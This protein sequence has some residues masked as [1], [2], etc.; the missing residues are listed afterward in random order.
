MKEVIASTC[1]ECSTK[2]G[3]LL[4]VEDGRVVK[5]G[6]NPN[7]PYSRGAFCVKGQS[8]LMGVTHASDRVLHPLRRVGPRGSGRWEQVSWDQAL[9]QVVESFARTKRQWG[10]RAICGAVSSALF[11][12]GPAMV[13]LMRS[14]GSPNHMINQ[15]LCQGCR[16]VSDTVTGMRISLGEEPAKASTIVLVGKNPAASNVVMWRSIKQ[17]CQNGARLIVVDPRRSQPAAKADVWLPIRPGTDA[18]L[19][20]GWIHILIRDG[21]YDREFVNRH[22]HGFDALAGRAAEY[23][24][25][26]VAKLTGLDV[27]AIEESAQMYGRN[28]P[29][30]IIL[31][32]GIDAQSN[33]VQTSRAFHTLIAIS[34]N[35]DLPGGHRR[36]RKYPGVLTYWDFVDLPQFRM[37][38]ERELETLGATEF[39]LWAGPDS[40]AK[41]CHN[42]TALRAMRTGE[43]YPVKALYASGVN[44][45]VT[46]PGMEDTRAALR[47]LDF[48]VVATSTMT[49]TAEYADLLL[50]KTTTL[51]EDEVAWHGGGPCVTVTRRGMTPLGEARTD[52]EIAADLYQRLRARHLLD[53]ELMPWTTHR[54]FVEYI[55][56]DSDLTWEQLCRDGAVPITVD[57]GNHPARFPTP[58]GRIELFSNILL[59]H[60]YDPL[61]NYQ[62][63]PG[64][65]AAG[66]ADSRH[67]L[68][69]ITGVRTIVYH[70]SRFREQ[71]W[72]RKMQPEPTVQLHPETA[73]ARGISGGDWV[74]VTTPHSMDACRHVAVL[75]DGVPAGAAITGMGWWYPEQPGPDH[76]A[77]DVNIN[78]VLSYEGACD[79][80]T[81][82]PDTRAIPCEVR[83]APD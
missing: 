30:T 1:W 57:Y 6:P 7:H 49:P 83:K 25:E 15:D 11:S 43:P 35:Y 47:Q 9:D 23:P 81:G 62:E 38:R 68:T 78:R 37:P 12:R 32:H 21:L 73:R 41:A 5:V 65:R 27:A 54:E 82:C 50:P 55:I 4:T 34:G 74:Q 39:P 61:P 19:A 56:R 53:H 76:G 58:S 77:L 52:I 67:P 17:A 22:C 2:C 3:S 31:G 75:D 40:W 18:A 70:H 13:L 48:L 72:A 69:L 28:R 63:P 60:G 79:P 45:V 33:G 46:Y 51:E 24:P 26:R 20:L 80:V 14:L 16:R 10:A 66:A 64:V 59:D 36:A 42:P 44:I 29:A 71:A 8:G